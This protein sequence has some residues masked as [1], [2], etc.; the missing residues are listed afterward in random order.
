VLRRQ[1]LLGGRWCLNPK[2]ELSNG[3]MEEIDR[4]C[5]RYPELTD[6]KFVQQFLAEDKKG[7]RQESS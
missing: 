6:D 5:Q 7:A 3:Q 4:I 1:G 2:E